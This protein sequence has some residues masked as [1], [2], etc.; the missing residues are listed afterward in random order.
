MYKLPAVKAPNPRL[1]NY[2]TSYFFRSSSNIYQAISDG[3][4]IGL[5]ISLPLC[6]ELLENHQLLLQLKL[7]QLLV[8]KDRLV[9]ISLRL[10]CLVLYQCTV[11]TVNAIE[12]IV[13]LQASVDDP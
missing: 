13:L 4:V 9:C 11:R 2:R 7:K 6:L 12:D 8:Y 5:A 10:H 3:D 1:L